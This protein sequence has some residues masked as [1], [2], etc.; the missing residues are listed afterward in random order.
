M[1]TVDEQAFLHHS[2]TIN[3]MRVRAMELAPCGDPKCEC[4]D[5]VNGLYYFAKPDLRYDE[6]LYFLEADVGDTDVADALADDALHEERKLEN[7][8][9]LAALAGAPWSIVRADPARVVA[10]HK[11]TVRLLGNGG[12]EALRTQGPPAIRKQYG[13]SDELWRSTIEDEPR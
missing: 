12:C 6:W 4:S 9:C 2:L 7:L 13:L 3:G 5:K 11:R 8:G 10:A 1:D